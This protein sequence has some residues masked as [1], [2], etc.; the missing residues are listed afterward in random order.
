MQRIG[1][2]LRLC[3][4]TTLL[5]CVHSHVSANDIAR[6]FLPE[7]FQP[8]LVGNTTAYVIRV[9][10]QRPLSLGLTTVFVSPAA[11]KLAFYPAL[12]LANTLAAKGWHVDI[13]TPHWFTEYSADSTMMASTEDKAMMEPS[14]PMAWQSNL[15]PELDYEALT[16]QL[17]ILLPGLNNVSQIVPGFRLVIAEG[18]IASLLLEHGNEEGVTLPDAATFISP[19]WPERTINDD[20]ASLTANYPSP[21]LDI[22]YSASSRFAQKNAQLRADTARVEVK[23]YYR[24]LKL[25]RIQA[26]SAMTWVGGEIVGWTRSL[27]W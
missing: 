17:K 25:T 21:L 20:I 3:L 15:D 12:K 24:Q 9:D 11:G 10:S 23:L 22:A 13:V 8:V 5:V 26:R 2:L 27:G 14:M 1:Q 4:V 7:Q 16:Q 19:F 18:L 6:Q